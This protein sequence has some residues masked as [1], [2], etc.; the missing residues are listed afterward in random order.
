MAAGWGGL[1]NLYVFLLSLNANA[2]DK[3]TVAKCS[4][5]MNNFNH[6]YGAQLLDNGYTHNTVMEDSLYV[7]SMKFQIGF[8]SKTAF[9]EKWDLSSYDSF[10]KF[11]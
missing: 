7:S 8:M 10:Y 6:K 2:W 3:N 1:R 5:Y 11:L 4:A 9:N